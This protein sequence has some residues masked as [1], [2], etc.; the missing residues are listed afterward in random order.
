M[1]PM[2]EGED[3]FAGARCAQ[4]ERPDIANYR[5]SSS[6]TSNTSTLCGGMLPAAWPP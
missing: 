1:R 3:A 2:R 5:M 6:S 4:D